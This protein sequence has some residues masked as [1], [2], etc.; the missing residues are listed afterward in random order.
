MARL[1]LVIDMIKRSVLS[2][3]PNQMYVRRGEGHFKIPLE[4]TEA[5]ASLQ[6]KDG[7]LTPGWYLEVLAVSENPEKKLRYMET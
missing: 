5:R 3:I 7:A 2:N 1:G 4:G 6:T